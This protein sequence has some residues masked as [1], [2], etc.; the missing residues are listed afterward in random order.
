MKFLRLLFFSGMTVFSLFLGFRA[1]LLTSSSS[2]PGLASS[3]ARAE[4]KSLIAGPGATGQVNLLLVTVDDTVSPERLISAWLMGYHH[5]NPNLLTFIPLYPGAGQGGENRDVDLIKQFQ[6]DRRGQISGKF[7]ES[8]GNIFRVSWD[9]IVT[10][11]AREVIHTIDTLGGIS[12]A[13]ELIGGRT[14]L[15]NMVGESTDTLAARQYQALTIKA[16]CDQ[17]ANRVSSTQLD[18]FASLLSSKLSASLK[19]PEINNEALKDNF[20]NT[21]LS[22]ETPTVSND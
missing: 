12:L 13:G 14:L 20:L 15:E 4:G 19:D 7:L 9:G 18:Q 3:D 22:C 16:T 8:L 17:I 10:I 21:R 1:G 2:E 6:I 11:S 5:N